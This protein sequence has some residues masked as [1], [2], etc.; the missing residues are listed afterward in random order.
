MNRLCLALSGLKLFNPVL[1]LK[2]KYVSD[3]CDFFT[4]LQVVKCASKIKLLF[5]GIE[6]KDQSQPTVS[7][8]TVALAQSPL[9]I[10][11]LRLGLT[12]VEGNCDA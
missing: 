11:H 2:S 8:W 4:V 12:A 3:L 10:N 6:P 5:I 1:E 7:A 9:Q